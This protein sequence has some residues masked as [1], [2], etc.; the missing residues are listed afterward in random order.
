MFR[1]CLWIGTIVFCLFAFFRLP[2]FVSAG[3]SPSKLGMY[4]VDGQD[5]DK[6]ATILSA[7]PAFLKIQVTANHLGLGAVAKSYKKSCPGGIVIVRVY[8]DARDKK[9][10]IDPVHPAQSGTDAANSFWDDFLAR[11]VADMKADGSLTGDDFVAGP[12]EY[13]NTPAITEPNAVEWY[14]SFWTQLAKNISEKGGVKPMLGEMQG[15]FDAGKAQLLGQ[16]LAA[17]MP[18]IMTA[19]GAW[20]HHAYGY[21]TSGDSAQEVDHAL[22]YRK[23]YAEISSHI[24]PSQIAPL[25][26][27]EVGAEH[28]QSPRAHAD[29][30]EA[31]LKWFDGEI[32]NDPY[33]SGG[34]I[35]EIGSFDGISHDPGRPDG[36]WADRDIAPLADDLKKYFGGSAMSG[37]PDSGSGGGTTTT[38][39]PP[40][41]FTG[42]IANIFSNWWTWLLSGPVNKDIGDVTDSRMP[43]RDTY[44]RPQ[45]ALGDTGQ[46]VLGTDSD[47]S[48]AEISHD[49]TLSAVGVLPE[50][51]QDKSSE[52]AK[53]TDWWAGFGWSISKIFSAGKDSSEKFLQQQFPPG[54]ELSETNPVGTVGGGDGGGGSVGGPIPAGDGSV[55]NLNGWTAVVLVEKIKESCTTD[56]PG[57]VNASNYPCLN[58]L[59]KYTPPA[60]QTGIDLLIE[61]ARD[62]KP[63]QCVGFVRGAV[64]ITTGQEIGSGRNAIDYSTSVPAGWVYVPLDSVNQQLLTTTD[65]S[66]KITLQPGDALF[67]GQGTAVGH[68]AIIA[69]VDDAASLAYTIAEANY[70]L[71]T[72]PGG[73]V[74]TR[75][76][77]IMTEISN[78][79]KLLGF[80]RKS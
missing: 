73:N 41:S 5:S 16:A 69:G 36:Q 48:A 9:Y 12:N 40:L 78:N 61:S 37:I 53:D 4:V 59:A 24:S 25:Y 39:C 33:V 54:E 34:T 13:D 43:T 38:Q 70:H 44:C 45:V 58:N 60:D 68:I 63:L 18:A 77:F 20:S 30:F 35:F 26:L 80:L 50:S 15:D 67:F 32:K 17:A 19:H 8:V 11:P 46:L 14:S 31:W 64:H 56:G 71:D 75:P 76:I 6:V 1:F 57:V 23:I 28:L 62:V 29:T 66:K 52:T 47:I 22:I 10:S 2:S 79:D 74:Q 3:L 72:E 65:T 21:S 51:I 27:T 55:P 42:S 49:Y 7:C